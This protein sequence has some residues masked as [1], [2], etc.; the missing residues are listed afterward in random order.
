MVVDEVEAGLETAARLLRKL[1]LPRN[2]IEEQLH[3]AREETQHSSRPVELPPVTLSA[4]ADLRSLEL[5]PIELTNGTPTQGKTLRQLE[6][7]ERTGALVVARRRAGVLQLDL[8]PDE[9]LLVGD[10]LYVAGPHEA[11][12]KAYTYLLGT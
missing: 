1:Q 9:P 12:A 2:R 8:G 10:I 11:L 5:E 3:L 7:R 4:N 6:L